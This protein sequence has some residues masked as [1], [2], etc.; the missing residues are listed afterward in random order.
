VLPRLRSVSGAVNADLNCMLFVDLIC[1]VLN[2]TIVDPTNSAK[3]NLCSSQAC[4]L[5]GINTACCLPA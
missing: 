2:D 1:L 4:L 3:G 5:R